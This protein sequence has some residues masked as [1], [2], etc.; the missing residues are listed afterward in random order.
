M[1]RLSRVAG[2]VA[3]VAVLVAG[4]AAFANV[5]G[6]DTGRPAATQGTIVYVSPHGN[7]A[8]SGMSDGQAVLTVQRAQRIVRSLDGDMHGNITVE[9]ASGTYRL[10]SPLTLR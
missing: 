1:I 5:A 4:A 3:A 10:S 2:F 7:D 9:L 8:N 6:A